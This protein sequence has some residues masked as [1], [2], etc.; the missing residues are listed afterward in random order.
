M[1]KN[2]VIFIGLVLFSAVCLASVPKQIELGGTAF[3]QAFENVMGNHKTSQYIP[4]G[5]TLN[6]WT[7][8][9]VVHQYITPDSPVEF[10]Q[11]QFGQNANIELID[12]EK[13]NILVKVET[14]NTVDKGDV[15]IYEQSI[16]RYKQ[17]SGGKGLI[18]VQYSTRVTVENHAGI[19]GVEKISQ[20]VV[21]EVKS[22]PMERYQF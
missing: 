19:G 11:K 13:N 9:V 18:V 3:N 20:S 6:D 1:Y 7:S 17:L 22:L 16:W 4:K 14:M 2:I 15:I 10:A 21:S 5:E 8:R 12:G